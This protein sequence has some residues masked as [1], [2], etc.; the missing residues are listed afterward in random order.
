M[1]FAPWIRS[2]SHPRRSRPCTS[3]FPR[4]TPTG[5]P[6][7]EPVYYVRR[8]RTTVPALTDR[9]ARTS[10]KLQG[11][12]SRS[13]STSVGQVHVLETEGR[14]TLPTLVLLHGFSSAGVHYFPLLH[15]LRRRVRRIV[16]P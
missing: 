4:S 5:R 9:L 6:R 15:L 12:R 13:I 11:Y 16:L 3:I 1:W 8:S 2:R 7:E 10:L 14:G